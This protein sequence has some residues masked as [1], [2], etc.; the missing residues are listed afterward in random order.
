MFG[1]FPP[2]NW[3]NV[4][5]AVSFGGV[6]LDTNCWKAVHM[7]IP[8]FIGSIPKCGIAPWQPFPFTVILNPSHDELKNPGAQA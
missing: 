1:V 8:T 7:L 5:L 3:P 4:K 2:E 6:S